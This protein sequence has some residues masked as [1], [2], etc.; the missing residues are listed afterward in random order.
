MK[1]DD[2]TTVSWWIGKDR[3]EF[4]KEVHDRE[5]IWLRRGRQPVSTAGE[6]PDTGFLQHARQTRR[7]KREGWA[8]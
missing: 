2:L 5:P 1:N 4:Y 3:P 7:V 8:A 6:H